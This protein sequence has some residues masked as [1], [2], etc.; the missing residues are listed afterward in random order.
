MP[1]S[2]GSSPNSWAR[3]AHCLRWRPG[4]GCRR[5]ARASCRPP[6]WASTCD[7]VNPAQALRRIAY[8]LEAEGAETYKVQAFRRAASTVDDV[9]PEELARLDDQGRLETLAG[10]GKSTAA[11]ISQALSGSVPEYLD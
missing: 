3:G 2:E 6:S 4:S 1:G 10:V 9:A 5:P 8:L 7:H 11:V